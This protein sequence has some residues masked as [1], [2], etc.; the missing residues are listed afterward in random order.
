VE[1]E[2]RGVQGWASIVREG[3]PHGR[4]VAPHDFGFRV[5]PAFETPFDGAYT[6]DTLFQFFLGMAVGVINGLR[7]LAEIMEVTE[8]VWHIGEHLRDGTADG[9]LAVRNETN[10]RHLHGLA[11]CP[12]QYCQVLLGR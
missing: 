10:N 12:E 9:Q 11:Y 4:T 7:G 1:F 5:A 2:S 8:L 3:T 6:T